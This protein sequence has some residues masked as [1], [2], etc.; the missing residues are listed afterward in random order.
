MS[1]TLKYFIRV[2]ISLLIII[3]VGIDLSSQGVGINTS[4][5]DASA[6]LDI[7]SE[8]KGLLI[9][10]MDSMH[11]KAIVSPEPG[12]MVYDTSTFSFWFFRDTAWRNLS[13][14]NMIQDTDGDTKIWMEKNAD[15]DWM[16]F[17]LGG[18]EKMFLARNSFNHPLLYLRSPKFNTSV[19]FQAGVSMNGEPGVD[20]LAGGSNTSFGWRAGFNTTS[21]HSNTF[22]GTG[23]GLDNTTGALNTFV[24]SGAG[25]SSETSAGNILIGYVAGSNNEGDNNIFIGN[26]AGINNATGNNNIYMG[27]STGAQNPDGNYNVIMGQS[28]ANFM[29][30]GSNNSMIG[31]LTANLLKQGSD[32]TYVGCQAGAFDTLG[33]DN[34]MLGAFAG[35]NVNGNRNVFIG[36]QAGT[37][38]NGDDQLVIENSNTNT[39]LIYGDFD[40]NTV[41]IHWDTSVVMTTAFNVNGK[42]FKTDG[43]GSWLFSSDK[44]LKKN[45]NP[46]DGNAILD[47]LTKIEGVTY[48]WNENKLN[49]GKS[50]DRQYGFIAQDIARLWP[51]KVIEDQNGYLATSYGDLDPMIIEAIK[52]LNKK[53]N[54][55]E[56]ENEELKNLLLELLKNKKETGE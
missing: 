4:T 43:G 8:T 35:A 5:P 27:N 45:I 14:P 22:I 25:S 46:L 29:T 42:A 18:V 26:Q 17:D 2:S 1:D 54:M 10:T 51:E 3:I 50:R 23:A 52:A 47:Q 20:G 44:R 15:E 24:G 53:L 16:R 30:G 13:S 37:N 39:P 34:T 7:K 11:R 38:S 6:A 28:S 9:P 19:G 49:D 56:N 21:G 55:L 41:G 12:L 32:N 36:H 31:G 33:N 40:Q 48:Y